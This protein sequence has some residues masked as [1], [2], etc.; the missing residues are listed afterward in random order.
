[1]PNDMDKI[2]PTVTFRNTESTPA[3]KAYAVE[4]VANVLKKYA[5]HAIDVHVVLS[6]QK[7]DHIAEVKISAKGSSMFDVTA[8]A[9]TED[10][11]SSIDK[12]MDTV[13]SQLRKK[14]EKVVDSKQCCSELSSSDIS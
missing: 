7:R 12:V 8:K 3:L 6:V 4:K 14:K 1:M 5:Q 2:N 13:Q 10:L 11:Y 9:V